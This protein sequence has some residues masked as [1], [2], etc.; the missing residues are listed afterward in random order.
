MLDKKINS[1]QLE[2]LFNSSRKAYDSDNSAIFR[3]TQAYS[4]LYD[5]GHLISNSG[6]GSFLL[7]SDIRFS[8]I[9][10]IP[11]NERIDKNRYEELNDISEAFNRNK[12]LLITSYD[13]LQKL[14]EFAGYQALLRTVKKMNIDLF[15]LFSSD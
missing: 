15:E 4:R 2:Q 10:T 5:E 9:K 13:Y 8:V 1:A 3:E 6:H 14:H 11:D 12:N 7:R